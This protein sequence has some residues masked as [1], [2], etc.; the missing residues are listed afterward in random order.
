MCTR[1]AREIVIGLRGAAAR[2]EAV[3]PTPTPPATVV[4]LAGPAKRLGRGARSGR[5]SS[6]SRL[7]SGNASRDVCKRVAS[8]S[9]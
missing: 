2:P 4:Q 8:G 5:G 6:L 7:P 9:R 3:P 1:L